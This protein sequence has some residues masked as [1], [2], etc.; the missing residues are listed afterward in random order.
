MDIVFKYKLNFNGPTP[1][2]G[3]QPPR[4][5]IAERVKAHLRSPLLRQV[6][7][8]RV[9]LGIEKYGQTLDEN[10]K[11]ERVKAVHLIQENL[12][13]AQ[14]GEWMGTKAAFQFGDAV[15]MQLAENADA[16]LD[17]YPDLT[18]EE[19][20]F[21]EGHAPVFCSCPGLQTLVEMGLVK[22]S[23]A[24]LIDKAG[25]WHQ[26]SYYHL[27]PNGPGGVILAFCPSCGERIQ[28]NEAF[29]AFTQP[30]P[31]PTTTQEHP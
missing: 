28:A 16:I 27:G 23:P 1:L 12:D 3:T 19:L 6:V 7:D 30:S 31:L 17:A 5:A 15:A 25:E 14:Y 10:I 18:L 13:G 8:A 20:L 22:H 21:Q 2:T 9:E 11:P 4:S 29:T 24:Q 26:L